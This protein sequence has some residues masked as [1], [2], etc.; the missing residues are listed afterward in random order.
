MSKTTSSL[1]EVTDA[2][3]QAVQTA[4]QALEGVRD[5]ASVAVDTMGDTMRDLRNGAVHAA[6]QGADTLSDAATAARREVNRY[7]SAGSRYASN[8]PLKT[9]LIAAA[10]GAVVAALL[11]A[12]ARRRAGE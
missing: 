5:F 11:L 2:A 10:L 12:L 3:E 7:A 8:E 6:R 4:A 9:A 1:N